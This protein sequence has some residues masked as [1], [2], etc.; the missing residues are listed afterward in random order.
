MGS[1]QIVK[2]YPPVGGYGGGG[3]GG[4]S[5]LP[6]PVP[7]PPKTKNISITDSSSRALFLVF[8]F[9]CLAHNRFVIKFV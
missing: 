1:D 5:S 8:H 6:F 7:S 9:V 3:G 2:H 4:G